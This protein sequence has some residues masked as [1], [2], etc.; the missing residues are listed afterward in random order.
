[1]NNNRTSAT[2]IVIAV[3]A[4]AIAT[5]SFTNR[6]SRSSS[7]DDYG[8]RHPGG[9]PVASNT[10]AYYKGSDYAERRAA[11]KLAEFNLGTDFAQRRMAA[12]LAEFNIGTDFAQRHPG[13]TV[14]AA[15]AIDRSD[16]FLRHPELLPRAPAVDTSDYF[17][18]HP[19][20]TIQ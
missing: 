3:V 11:A 8:L 20:L 4:L 15:A 18:R 19:E 5:S 10:G 16:Y 13:M 12:Q 1:M 6:P 17:L 14:W 2:V 7:L 9:M